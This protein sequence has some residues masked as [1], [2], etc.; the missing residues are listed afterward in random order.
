MNNQKYF[1]TESGKTN[2]SRQVIAYTILISLM[3]FISYFYSMIIIAIPIIYLNI[4]IT[5]GFG[6]II[7]VLTRVSVRLTH[8]RSKRSRYSLAIILPII[9]T[10]FQWSTYISYL[11]LNKIP[12]FFELLK[13]LPIILLPQNFISI[14]GEI[15]EAGTWALFDNS[16]MGLTLLLI[17]LT[18]MGITVAIPILFMKDLKPSAY[19]ELQQKWYTKYTLAN[20]FES[21]PASQQ[22]T[23]SLIN[24]PIDTIEN[25]KIGNGHR[26]TKIHLLYLKEENK[27]YL[28]FERISIIGKGNKKRVILINNFIISNSIAEKLLEN[29]RYKKERLDL[30]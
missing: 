16:I 8:N 25:L 15:Y 30:F 14:I 12:S 27:Q 2:L 7:G 3:L 21:I 24:S 18:E 1:Y 11:I 13:E 19:S 9:A 10:I 6:I 26:H 22:L 4:V 23:S 29:Y 20:D 5:L 17:W 28:T